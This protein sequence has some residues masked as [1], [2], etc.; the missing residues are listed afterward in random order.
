[1]IIL[2]EMTNEHVRIIKKWPEYPAEFTELDHALR[3]GG[4]LDSDHDKAFSAFED[5]TII[6]FVVLWKSNESMTVSLALKGDQIGK[7]LGYVVL[8]E[9]L[10]KCFTEFGCKKVFLD[11]RKTNL[12]AKKLY[13]KVGFKIV[14]EHISEVRGKQVPFYKMAIDKAMF[15]NSNAKKELDNDNDEG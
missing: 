2:R 12:R 13:D 15:F 10:V 14:G 11:V 4:W 9:T 8:C 6:G 1:M 3:D 5:Q 7:G